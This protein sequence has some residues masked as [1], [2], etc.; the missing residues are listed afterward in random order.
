MI[1]EGLP[2]NSLPLNNNP[3]GLDVA[4]CSTHGPGLQRKHVEKPVNF[5]N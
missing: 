5:V 4:A 2:I 1:E 3:L